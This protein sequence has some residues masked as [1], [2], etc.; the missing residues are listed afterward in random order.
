M[1]AHKNGEWWFISMI[2]SQVEAAFDVGANVG[3]WAEEVLR[4]CPHLH[5]LS[6][7]EPS[8]AATIKMEVAFGSDP[9]V[10]IVRVAVSDTEGSM[11]FYE[12]PDASQTSSL[13]AGDNRDAPERLVRVVTIDQEME[14]LSLDH[15]DL[16]KIDVEGYDLHALRGARVALSRQAIS[17]VQ[18]EYNRPWMY[19]GST[20]Q[21]AARLLDE[22]DY[23]LFL[24]NNSGLCR[25]DVSRLGELF[26]YL[27]FVAVPRPRIDQLP[28]RINPDPI[29]D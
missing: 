11:P 17:F 21:A 28:V 4:S 29:W 20:L 18:F 9:R 15:L 26:V 5:S 7:F 2:G 14:R 1:E 13:V 23:A 16:L 25:C 3:T 6:C 19:A 12:Q 24:L 10:R 22:Y 27:N 8:E